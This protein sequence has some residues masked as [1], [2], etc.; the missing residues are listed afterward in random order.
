MQRLVLAEFGVAGATAAHAQALWVA[1]IALSSLQSR[2][3]GLAEAGVAMPF[4]M[5]EI[6]RM[7][8]LR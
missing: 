6:S 3:V 5:S 8:Q 4:F 1:L 2:Y 7:T